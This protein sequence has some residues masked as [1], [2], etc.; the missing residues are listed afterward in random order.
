M[1]TFRQYYSPKMKRVVQI[2]KNKTLNLLQCNYLHIFFIKVVL[3]TSEVIHF[4]YF[5]VYFLKYT[6]NYYV[7]VNSLS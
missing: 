3:N 6:K 5:F 7:K 2:Y 4:V 1:I